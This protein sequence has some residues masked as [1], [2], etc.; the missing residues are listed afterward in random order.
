MYL[1]ARPV[2]TA[3][4]RP[5]ERSPQAEQARTKVNEIKIAARRLRLVAVLR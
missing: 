3:E 2:E 1:P 4:G 5:E